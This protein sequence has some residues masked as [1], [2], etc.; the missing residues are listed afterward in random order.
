MKDAYSFDLDYEG[1][2]RAYDN[3]FVAYLRTFKRMGLTAI[4]MQAETG[5]IGGD[6]EPRVPSS[7][8]RP[9]RAPSSTTRPSSDGRLRVDTATSTRAPEWP[10]YAATDEMHDPAKCPVPADR[11]RT[12]RGIEVGHIFYFG[13]KYSATMGAIVIGPDGDR[14]AG[15]D[16][17]LR[18]RR[19]APRRRHHRGLP[20][21]QGHRLARARRARSASASSIC[22]PTTRPAATVAE[23]LYGRSA[24]RARRRALR[25]PRGAG[26]RQVRHHGPDRP[27]LAARRSGRAASRRT[28]SS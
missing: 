25:R 11:L 19:L 7:W 3:M 27:A 17:L 22:A 16:G 15:R 1:A 18:H 4:P 13:T 14:D 2:R 24:R 23:D 9:A 28:G 10:L 12:G 26:R 21:R 8:P 20:R 6:H 5:P